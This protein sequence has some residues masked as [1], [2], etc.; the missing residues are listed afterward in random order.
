MYRAKGGPAPH[1]PLLLLLVLKLAEKGEL[2]ETLP[3]TPEL[4]FRFATFYSVVV[5]RRSQRP[6]VRMPFYHLRSEG[7]WRSLD[8]RGQAAGRYRQAG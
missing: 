4:A 1:K 6:D 5:H 3:L 2:A 8:E 7:F